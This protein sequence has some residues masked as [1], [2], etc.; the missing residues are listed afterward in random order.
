MTIY[1]EARSPLL[2]CKCTCRKSAQI[3]KHSSL[4]NV[5]TPELELMN[6]MCTFPNVYMYQSI[7]LDPRTRNNS[8]LPVK[9][10]L[11]IGN[12]IRSMGPASRWQEAE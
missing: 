1:K 7:T 4:L 11:R 12:E 10:E 8:Y 2:A 3:F 5:L 6:T 9:N